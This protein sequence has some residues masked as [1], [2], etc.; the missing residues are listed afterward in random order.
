MLGVARLPD[1]LR[2]E[3]VNNDLSISFNGTE[4]RPICLVPQSKSTLGIR[5]QMTSPGEQSPVS[6]FEQTM[7]HAVDLH[8]GTVWVPS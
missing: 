4:Y 7:P 8:R 5:L 6:P 2:P 1:I 3:K